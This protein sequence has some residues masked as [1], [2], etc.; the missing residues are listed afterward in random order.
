MSMFTR[1]R[2]DQGLEGS[3]IVWHFMVRGMLLL[4]VGRLVDPPFMLSTLVR[5]WKGDSVPNHFNP[6]LNY[7]RSHFE[8]AIEDT[9]LG[10]FEVMTGLGLT[11]MCAALFFLLPLYYV[12]RHFENSITINDLEEP[13]VETNQKK[14]SLKPPVVEII[15]YSLFLCI[16]MISNIVIVHAQGD[17]FFLSNLTEYPH[18]SARATNFGETFERFFLIPGTL[19]R[20][21]GRAAYPVIPWLG[22]TVL[23]MGIGFS[24]KSHPVQSFR[25]IG[26]LS[27]LFLF[28]FF[29]IRTIGG[30]AGNLR[31]LPRQDG[32]REGEYHVG[33]FIAYF[34]TCKYPPSLAFNLLNVGIDFGLIY[35]FFLLEPVFPLVKGN[36]FRDVLQYLWDTILIFGQV[37]LF[38]YILHFWM[39]A[40]FSATLAFFTSSFKFSLP[41]C[42]LAWIGFLA[43]LRPL[44]EKYGIFKVSTPRDSVW[45]YL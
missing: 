12:D 16:Y 15:G 21:L 25:R 19:P 43:I 44:C 45:R 5:V 28:G 7:T 39:I 6:G 20:P 29:V 18:G 22:T 41:L 23:G 27:I 13:L 32:Q 37:P 10:V 31:G 24:M 36:K 14:S 1:V 11:M 38:F 17:D 26:W 9:F 8:I 30:A 42:A 33:L 35:G 3:L 40:I 2:K 34:G 4:F